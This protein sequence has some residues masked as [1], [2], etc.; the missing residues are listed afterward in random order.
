MQRPP[1]VNSKAS[2]RDRPV[3]MLRCCAMLLAAATTA[4]ASVAQTPLV[5]P[6]VVHPRTSIDAIYERRAI[7]LDAAQKLRLL[8]SIETWKTHYRNGR[9]VRARCGPQ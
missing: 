7:G 1:V 2:L 6:I 5:P 3:A 8:E 9:A 4:P